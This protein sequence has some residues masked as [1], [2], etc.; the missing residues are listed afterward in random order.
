MK[1]EK[2][3]EQESLEL[4]TAMITQTKERCRI[5]EGSLMISWG[6]LTVVVCA[7]VWLLL[8][9]NGGDVHDSWWYITPIASGIFLPLLSRL[10]KQI[11]GVRSFSDII[12]SKLWIIVSIACA[13]T[14]TICV[15]SRFMANSSY[16]NILFTFALVIV[17]L[18]E[19]FQGLVVKEKSYIYGG[20]AGLMIGLF[21][22]SCIDGNV[23]LGALLYL[24]L[25]M[26]AIIAMMI[27]PGHI[28]N[29]KARA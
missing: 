7:V 21:T 13:L 6:Y 18:A 11:N 10:K 23:S 2:L 26:L 9:I 15:F 24:P 14:M 29:H 3:S 4:I 5:G 12:I 1:E 22:I 27:I 20:S 28:I 8:I 16:T 17:P 19:M 25:I